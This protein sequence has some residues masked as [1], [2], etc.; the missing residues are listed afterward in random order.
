MADFDAITQELDRWMTKEYCYGDGVTS[1]AHE[2][3]SYLTRILYQRRSKMDPLW[4]QVLVA[5]FDADDKPMLGLADLYGTAFKD[6]TIATGYGAYIVQGKMR[7][8]AE[9]SSELTEE[10]ARK[11]LIQSLTVLY[12][13]D[14]RA[15]NEVQIATITKEGAK[16]SEP[17]KID[18]DWS[19]GILPK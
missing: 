8:A 13:R 12:Y 2:V 4:N 14:A 18:T 7:K 11:L 9:R 17:F 15:M 19:I 3:H 5:G 16:I 10:E 6:S 1:N